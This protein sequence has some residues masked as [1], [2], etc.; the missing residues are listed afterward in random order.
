MS[1]GVENNDARICFAPISTAEIPNSDLLM[2]LPVRSHISYA[3]LTNRIFST[4]FLIHF[5]NILQEGTNVTSIAA[6]RRHMTKKNIQ[7]NLM[8]VKGQEKT[9]CFI[10]GDGWFLTPPLSSPVSAFDLLFQIYYFSNLQ[11]PTSLINIFNFLA[12]YVYGIDPIFTNSVSSLHIN[13]KN[14]KHMSSEPSTSNA[15]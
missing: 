3:H 9:S 4:I 7:P 8:F 12:N 15:E 2:I 11:F 14:F 13:I 10:Q 1:P 5:N 6:E